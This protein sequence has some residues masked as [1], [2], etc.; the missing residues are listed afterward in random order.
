VHG[1]RRVPRLAPGE[2]SKGVAILTTPP[3]AA[4]IAHFLLACADGLDAVVERDELNNCRAS[5]RRV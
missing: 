3:I 4:P 2:S 1:V 5:R